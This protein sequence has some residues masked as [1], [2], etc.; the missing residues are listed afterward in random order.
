M[1][2]SYQRTRSFERLA[3][4]YLSTGNLDK[5]RKMLKLAE[6]RGDVMGAFHNALYLGDVREQVRNVTSVG[7]GKGAWV[8]CLLARF[9]ALPAI[10]TAV[11]N[12]V[13]QG[14]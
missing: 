13:V 5:L 1:E 3:F 10:N 12:T 9:S 8:S 7:W 14:T 2:F 6:M 4:L 11:V